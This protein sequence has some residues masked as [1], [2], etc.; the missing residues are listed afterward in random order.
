MNIQANIIHEAARIH[1][2]GAALGF[3]KVAMWVGNRIDKLNYF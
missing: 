3:D 2:F 1:A